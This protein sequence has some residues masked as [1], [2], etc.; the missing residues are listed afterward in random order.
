MKKR[1]NKGLVNSMDRHKF[2]EEKLIEARLNYL[3]ELNQSLTDYLVNFEKHIRR[4]TV[5]LKGNITEVNDKL[6][7]IKTYIK[8]EVNKVIEKMIES[9][10]L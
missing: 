5:S 3:S 2:E 9:S 4:E 6:I 8:D 7:N 10:E 1:E